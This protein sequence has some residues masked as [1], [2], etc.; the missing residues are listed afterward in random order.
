MM[1]ILS[2]G[3]VRKQNSQKG[4]PNIMVLPNVP[5]CCF[6][7]ASFVP[8][9]LRSAWPPCLEQVTQKSSPKWW[10]DSVDDWPWGPIP[11]KITKKNMF[12]FTRGCLADSKCSARGLNNE[13]VSW[14][15]IKL[16][17][18]FETKKWMTYAPEVWHIPW[19]GTM[20]KDE[21]GISCS[22][23]QFHGT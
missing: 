11:K 4:I 17:L 6:F 18:Y 9:K 3:K 20:K 7:L 15:R 21:K 23:H 14:K 8:W 13:T 12:K 16:C 19:K 5:P 10:F 1:F 22:N 2:V